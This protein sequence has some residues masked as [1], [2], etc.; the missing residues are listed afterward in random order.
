MKIKLTALI[1][2]HVLSL[3]IFAQS[4]AVLSAS[5]QDSIL[6][7]TQ[8]GGCPVFTIVTSTTP[9]TCNDFT[10]G[11]VM[12]DEPLDG[13]GPYVYQWVGG[14]SS[15]S[16]AGLGAGTYTI[17]VIDVGQSQSCSQDVFL[18]E[19]G[20]LTVFTMQA[21]AP[22]CFGICDGQ[23]NPIVIGGN[24][25]YMFSYDSG[26][27]TQMATM[28]CDPFQLTIT[29]ME[30]CTFDTT[31]AYPDGPE[32]IV[33]DPIITD[34]DCNGNDNGSIEISIS[35]GTPPFDTNWTGPGTFT[36][37]DEDI[38]N[39]E[40]GTYDL[41]I[42]D[43]NLCPFD[44]SYEI[45]EPQP[46]MLS[47][48]HMD[49]PCFGDMLGEIDVTVTGGTLDYM[50]SWTG[51]G[52]FTSA[53][54]DISGLENG[55][56]NLT[57]TDDNGCQEMISVEIESPDAIVIDRIIMDITCFGFDDGSIDITPSGGQGPY[58]YD[59]T[60]PP[61]FTSMNED[62]SGL[63]PGDYTIVVT[64]Q[65]DCTVDSTFTI[66]EPDELILTSTKMD[67]TCSGLMDGSIDLTIN[68]G[69][70]P[71]MISWTGPGTFSSTDE[72]IMNLEMGSYTVTVT[73][74]NDCVAMLTVVIEEPDVI[75]VVPTLTD[76]A[77]G[78]AMN[79]AIDI[80]V[81]GGTEP[82]DFMWVGPGTFTSN[83]E[84]INMLTA[85]TY[86]LTITDDN[87]CIFTASYDVLED[88]GFTLTFNVTDINC[89]GDNTG[90]IDMTITGGIPLFDIMWTGPNAFTSSLEDI[91]GLEAGTYSVSVT[92]NAGCNDMQ[93]V[94]VMQ[95][96]SIELTFT[97]MDPTC[98]GFDDGF[99]DMEIIGG[100]PPYNISWTGP[101]AFTSMDEDINMLIG[102][103]YDVVVTDALDCVQQ[104]SVTLTDPPA[105]IIDEILTDLVC[106]QDSS[107]SIEVTITLT[108]SVS[109]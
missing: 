58:D 1:A 30:G 50:Y 12:V 67:I 10:D 46:L 83:D 55:T 99:I 51:P 84:D 82:Y 92:D 89:F 94:D 108:S 54:E 102:G 56:Y 63:G 68:G 81:T 44:A 39:L 40:P 19:P 59:W 28:L 17:I 22:S 37:T 72:D 26:E 69:T 98:N 24:G 33:V 53:D 106:N 64:D 62:I 15:Q 36:S 43:A 48:T 100:M 32:P 66:L 70:S 91:N 96:D 9:P 78:G 42:L 21:V 95:N 5:E 61:P 79:G 45:M 20:D 105:I 88:P 90:A 13:V 74:A 49:N 73:D 57:V 35:G 80:D 52:T 2:L 60:G 6:Q 76:E 8:S 104:G 7:I 38:F 109:G 18:N 3:S 86:D 103:T 31:F 85:G 87:G 75:D 41:S 97:F 47:E 77:C 34:I 29:D 23:A 4:E 25:G 93:D 14:P 11:A 101:S 107:G 27:M 71:F 65:N 16:W